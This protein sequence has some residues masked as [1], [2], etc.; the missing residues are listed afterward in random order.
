MCVCLQMRAS[1]LTLWL[2]VLTPIPLPAKYS[3]HAQ[4]CS[5]LSPYQLEEVVSA[6]M[7]NINP[8]LWTPERPK[9][10]TIKLMNTFVKPGEQ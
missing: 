10:R 1:Y 5:N 3:P 8:Q 2:Y 4:G 7:P 9:H 6:W